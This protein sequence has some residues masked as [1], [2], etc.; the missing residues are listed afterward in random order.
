MLQSHLGSQT[1][2]RNKDNLVPQGQKTPEKPYES[3]I[4]I[5]VLPSLRI[6]VLRSPTFCLSQNIKVPQVVA[7]NCVTIMAFDI[8]DQ[9][10]VDD[11][12]DAQENG[13]VIGLAAVTGDVVSRLDIDDLLLNEK[14]CFNLFLLAL[15]ALQAHDQR[16]KT[17]SY[18][19]IAGERWLQGCVQLHC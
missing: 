13:N 1:R 9:R 6:S 7:Q 8:R 11:L 17:M 14:D 5:E 10:A 15:Q 19:Q 18:Y 12:R 16:S 4:H 3:Q 2:C